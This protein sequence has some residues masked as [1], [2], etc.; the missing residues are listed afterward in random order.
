MGDINKFAESL[1]TSRNRDSDS[2]LYDLGKRALETIVEQMN[3]PAISD[4]TKKTTL[5]E[6]GPKLRVCSEG[7]NSYLNLQANNLVLSQHGMAGEIQKAKEH[8]IDQYTTEYLHAR[9]PD[10]AS[11]TRRG[12]D[13]HFRNVYRNYVSGAVGIKAQEDRYVSSLEK[14]GQV[15]QSLKDDYVSFIEARLTPDRIAMVLAEQQLGKCEEI[16][17][18]HL[19]PG[20]RKIP[21]EQYDG[22]LQHE[23]N[24]AIGST[25]SNYGAS[26][27]DFLDYHME[28]DNE[29]E[30]YVLR[31]DPS[32]L[33]AS[34]IEG[35]RKDRF[36]DSDYKPTT[37]ASPSADNP[38][39]ANTPDD[40]VIKAVGDVA[41]VETAGSEKQSLTIHHPLLKRINIDEYPHVIV[42]LLR[43]STA[44]EI[45]Q[46]FP[47]AGALVRHPE[48]V[49]VLAGKM[50]AGELESY[51]H[52]GDKTRPDE[53]SQSLSLKQKFRRAVDNFVMKRLF[54][55][56]T[57]K[58]DVLL[59]FVSPAAL[60]T[61]DNTTGDSLL[62]QALRRNDL[63]MARV[64]V[65]RGVDLEL[66]NKAG[67]TAFGLAL[68]SKNND[69]AYAI[70]T[71]D[72]AVA[73]V[74]R[75]G[76]NVSESVY[77]LVSLNQNPEVT[78]RLLDKGLLNPD[79]R[80]ATLSV[81]FPLLH[82]VIRNNPNPAI[83]S[84]LVKAGADVH[85]VDNRGRNALHAISAKTDSRVVDMLINEQVDVNRR[86]NG[87]FTPLHRVATVRGR[88]IPKILGKLIDG[89]ADVNA[90]S[91]DGQ[92]RTPLHRTAMRT[93][94]PK[95]TSI[96]LAKGADPRL[97]DNLGR[98]AVH[99]AAQFNSNKI[100]VAKFLD[101]PA[102]DRD[103]G[104]RLRD[105]RDVNGMTAID[106]ARKNPAFNDYSV[107][108]EMGLL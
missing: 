107:L 35:L 88:A 53:T 58:A 85:A 17:G 79:M 36:I 71:P 63:D 70:A 3:N 54:H 2:P 5:T 6:L 41:W 20:Q 106:C 15:T 8:L 89:G 84:L 76:V 32:L 61:Q 39:Q 37:V 80:I 44:D 59:K 34:I 77:K 108:W 55:I 25:A 52:S 68:Q 9:H 98:N 50:S 100:I 51:L 97:K 46:V 57:R 78:Q 19:E 40:S 45:R 31:S 82:S 74:G 69:V 48:I 93:D 75:K 64:L 11:G 96:L 1:T 81:G 7:I 83:F 73:L 60:N 103:T 67:Q 13:V 33:A 86:D 101:L 91:A 105:V 10:V 22:K 4:E 18:R 87:G 26:S 38:Q 104:D 21:L 12:M 14:R 62:H 66:R 23:M 65:K 30:Y 90:R 95:V 28:D 16:M 24:D 99:L 49:E 43:K 27:T 42:G 94:D 72:Q 92:G 102:W 47:D 56:S 29:E